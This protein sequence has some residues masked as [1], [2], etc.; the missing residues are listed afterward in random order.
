MNTKEITN[1]CKSLDEFRI[2]L[3]EVKKRRALLD[4]GGHQENISIHISGITVQITEM[5]FHSRSKLKRGYD[6][7]GLGLIK[8]I[9]AEMDKTEVNIKNI[10]NRIKELTQ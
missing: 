1:L 3:T 6:M 2:Y 7:V 4:F 5:D 10:E 8:V 9:E